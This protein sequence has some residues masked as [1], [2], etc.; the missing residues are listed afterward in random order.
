MNLK[1]KVKSIVALSLILG[2]TIASSN[3]IS[4]ADEKFEYGDFVDENLIIQEGPV[5]MESRSNKISSAINDKYNYPYFNSRGWV[6]IVDSNNSAV[7]HYT[8]AATYSLGFKDSQSAQKFG[9]GKV[10][11]TNNKDYFQNRGFYT[12][13]FYGYK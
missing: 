11:Q 3:I 12:K 8:T 6:N 13:I 1:K 7:Y 4:F 9:Y 5:T 2:G 10:E